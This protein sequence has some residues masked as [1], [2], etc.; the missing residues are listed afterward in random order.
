[1]IQQLANKHPEIA[2]QIREVFQVSYA[3][4]AKLLRAVD[5]PPLKR[6]IEAFLKTE[7]DFYGFYKANQLAAVIEIETT[8]KTDQTNNSTSSTH[9]QSLVVR[10]E[11]FRQGIARSL[12]N[13]VFNV[14]DSEVFSVETGLA[15]EPAIN[16]YKKFGFVEVKQWDT[17]HG[18]I[19]VRFER[20]TIV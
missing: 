3:V 6:P 7:T 20:G 4:E 12:I 15:N 11:Y 18:V 8:P 14:C 17:N 13:F 5:F 1:M 19:K 10:P 2:Q 16:L 9:I